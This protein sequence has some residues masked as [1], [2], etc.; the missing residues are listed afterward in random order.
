MIGCT[1]FGTV[2]L[3]CSAGPRQDADRKQERDP[4]GRERDERRAERPERE[5]DDAKMRTMLAAS[6]I[7]SECSIS[8]NCA[9]RAGAAPVTPTT[10]PRAPPS[11]LSA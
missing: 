3:A 10:A 7:G 9:R 1:S 6:M 11:C 5:R 4:G 8:W 2:S